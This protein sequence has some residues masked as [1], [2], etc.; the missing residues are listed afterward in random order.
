MFDE[1]FL[2]SVSTIGA[3]VIGEYPEVVSYIEN[4]D[5]TIT[6]EVNAVWPQKDVYKRQILY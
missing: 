2:M 6:L 3:F 4:Q 5:G 1:H